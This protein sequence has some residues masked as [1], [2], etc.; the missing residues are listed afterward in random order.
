[1]DSKADKKFKKALTIMMLLA[2]IALPLLYKAES[3]AEVREGLIGSD[4]MINRHPGIMRFHVVANS[5]SAED[6]ELKLAVRDY[7]LSKVQGEIARAINN[8]KS[9]TEASQ[10]LIM[11]NYIKNNLHQ[12]R[13]WAQEAV[14]DAGFEYKAAADIGIRHIPAKY[15]DE[16]YFPEGNYEALT[17]TLGEGK[18]KNWWCVVFPPLCL[19]DSE[20]SAYKEEFDIE[21][22]ERLQLK[23]KTLELLSDDNLPGSTEAS[24]SNTEISVCIEAILNS[25]NKTASEL[26]EENKN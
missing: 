13:Q 1:M 17:I 21:E 4:G 14:D 3:R 7:V 2:F 25:F 12:I 19:I 9:N 23:F 10:S 26:S 16:L 20:D 18:G 15:Y 8:E 11:R 5:D 22:E 24:E 6:Q